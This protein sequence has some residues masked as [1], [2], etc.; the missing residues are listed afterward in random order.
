MG[1]N[2]LATEVV[3]WK[4]V[5][6]AEGKVSNVLLFIWVSSK[7]NF[8]PNT[9]MPRRAKMMRKRKSSSS[10][11]QM[12]FIEFSSEVTRSERAAQ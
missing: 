4:Q 8:P 9:C 7:L 6:K 5:S 3:T 11:E 10:R 12:A 2:N 1:N